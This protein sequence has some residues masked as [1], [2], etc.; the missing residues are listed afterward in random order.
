MLQAPAATAMPGTGGED[1]L[2][3]KLASLDL[4]H[5]AGELTDE[6]FAAAK[7]HLLDT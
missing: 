2:V 7:R 1:E 4:L 6:E 5:R 3:E